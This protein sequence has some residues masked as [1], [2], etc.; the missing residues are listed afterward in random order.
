MKDVPLTPDEESTYECFDCGTV[1]RAPSG[2]TC[3]D[4]GGDMRNRG[5]PIE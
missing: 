3:P 2:T 4:C 5:T 1:V